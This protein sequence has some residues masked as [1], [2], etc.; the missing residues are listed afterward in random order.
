MAQK[1][2]FGPP[3]GRPS[4]VWFSLESDDRLARMLP[5]ILP[6][7]HVSL[8]V[9]TALLS[10]T[11]LGGAWY[12][13]LGIDLFVPA[14]WDTDN[15]LALLGIYLVFGTP[16][17]YFIGRLGWESKKRSISRLSSGLA[18]ILTLFFGVVGTI[19]SLVSLYQDCREGHQ[20]GAGIIQ[21]PF[22]GLLCLGAF[23]SAVYS[24][25]AALKKR[26]SGVQ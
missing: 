6:A 25:G 7:T 11:D 18:A 13:I 24:A 15:N 2:W 16:W 23:L 5:V 3:T 26:G 19:F 1:L 10:P 12:R 17:W 21:Y 20:P 8:C 4:T 9:L 22:V 14:M